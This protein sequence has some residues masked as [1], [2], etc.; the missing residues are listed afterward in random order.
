MHSFPRTLAGIGVGHRNAR[1]QADLA[2]TSLFRDN[3]FTIQ[4]PFAMKHITPILILLLVASTAQGQWTTD[5]S[6]NTP[7]RTLTTGE[8]TSQ[9]IADGPNGSTYTCWFE[10]VSGM[11][12]LRMQR[13]DAGG[14]NLWPDTGL[15][16]S[17]HPQNSAIFRYDLQS[18][19]DGNAIVAFQDERTGSLDIVAYKIAPDGE[20]LWGADGVELPTPGTTGLAPS[21]APLEN[22]NTVIA[23]NTN[24]SPG[25]VAAQLVDPNGT[26]LLIVPITISAS[27]AVS[28][29]KPVGTSDGGFILQYEV[30]NGGFGL[31][32]ST[33]YAQR[34]DAGG[35]AAWPSAVQLSSTPVAFFYFPQPVSD[36]HDGLYLAY[37]SSNPDNPSF[38]DVFVQRLRENGTLWSTEGTRLD[39][40]SITQKFTA[41]KGLVWINDTDGLMIPLQVTDG[42]QGQSG[43]AVQRVDTAGVRQLGDAAVTIIPVSANYTSPVDIS[44]TE[45]GAVLVHST[46]GFGQEHFAATRVDLSGSPAWV[47]AQRDISTADSNKGDGAL[48]STRDGQAVVV[49]Q[50]DRTPNGIYAQN[51]AELS[52]A[53]GSAAWLLPNIRLESNPADSP[54]LIMGPEMHESRLAVFDLQGKQVYAATLPASSNRVELPLRGLPTGIYA[55]RVTG[56]QAP[57]V[58]RWVK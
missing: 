33:M 31:P 1:K 12:Q 35:T 43:V 52:T 54:V 29:P 39:N 14:N 30:S 20:F 6:M 10:N 23:W 45:D 21:L 11:Y 40:S 41:G 36:G 18:D 32:P 25:Q 55:I 58:L 24:D 42:A 22:G 53:V 48:T 5:V 9:L 46:G 49:W 17:A 4:Q 37:N 19:R 15:V 26:L 8:A 47:P 34:Y 28:R 57:R 27:T 16:V 13:V 38:T 51:I 50:D 7:V 2:Y 3:N 56:Q 44:A